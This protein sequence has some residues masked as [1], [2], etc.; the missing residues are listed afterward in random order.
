MDLGSVLVGLF[1]ISMGVNSLAKGAKHLREGLGPSSGARTIPGR[2]PTTF[3][4]RS[5][6]KRS[7]KLVK[8]AVPVKTKGGI[9]GTSFYEVNSLND[10]LTAIIDRAEQGK[11]DPQV[12][13]FARKAV[14]KRKPGSTEWNGGQWQIPEKRKDL[15]AVEIFKAVRSSVRYTSDPTTDT[16]AKP[17]NTL[18]IG[19]GDCDE[20][21]A[22]GCAASMAIGIPCRLK[23]I[24]T[25]QSADGGPDH[26]YWESFANGRWIPMDASVNMGPDW[27]APDSMVRRRWIY[28]VR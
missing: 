3:V 24:A 15:E 5:E 23:V 19:A 6:T 2:V 16:Y 7:L 11:T 25:K 4:P 18:N 17:R 22:L 14:S 13:A 12:I 21:A 9:M 26:I 1:A 10:R 27:E 28:E 20:Y 8:A